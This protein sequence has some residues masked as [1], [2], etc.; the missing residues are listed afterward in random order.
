MQQDSIQRFSDRAENYDKFRP[1]YPQA[2]IEFLRETIPITPD[3]GI[4]DIAAG[5]G[6]FTELITTW[7]SR[8]YVVEPNSYMRSLAHRRLGGCER[9]IFLDGTAEA[10]GLPDNS[11][12]LFVSAQA[13]H[14]FDL[15]KTRA[16][17]ERAGRNAPY[18]AVVWN[19]RNTRS[20]FEAGYESFVRT[21]ATD[22]LQVS[23]RKMNTAD[24]RSFF[25]PLRPQ[26]R[27]FR[28]VDS[29]TYPQLLGRTLSYSFLPDEASPVLPE[30]TAALE[31]LF[32]AHQRKGK[33]PLSYKTR[34]FVGMI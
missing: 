25:A 13:F 3:L 16:E 27:V 8:L 31:A 22:Y 6:I 18:V 4:A 11:V 10:T 15:A 26:Y 28:H 34:L 12:D 17:F 29:L 19:L 30:M 20:A 7:G 24:V 9:C 32:Q 14:W 1:G 33:V 21:Y 23:Q 5:T 2:L